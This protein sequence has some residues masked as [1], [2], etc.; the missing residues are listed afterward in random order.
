MEHEPVPVQAPTIVVPALNWAAQEEPQSM[1]GGDE[2]I[3]PEPVP[4]LLIS[5]VRTLLGVRLY[6]KMVPLAP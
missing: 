5:R 2:A 6:E 4:D 1:P 3:A